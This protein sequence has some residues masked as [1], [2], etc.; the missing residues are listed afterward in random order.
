MRELHSCVLYPIDTAMN[1]VS[2]RPQTLKKMLSIILP[3]EVTVLIFLGRSS[4]TYFEYMLSCFVSGS[5]WWFSPLITS[6]D[7]FRESGKSSSW[8]VSSEPTVYTLSG[9]LTCYTQLSSLF[10]Y[11]TLPSLPVFLLWHADHFSP[12][13][14]VWVQPWL[15]YMPG[16]V[17]DHHSYTPGFHENRHS[18]FSLTCGRR[19]LSLYTATT[20]QWILVDLTL[21]AVRNLITPRILIIEFCNVNSIRTVYHYQLDKTHECLDHMQAGMCTTTSDITFMSPDVPLR[22]SKVACSNFN[23]FGCY[24]VSYL[25]V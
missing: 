3:A 10:K 6:N 23:W 21:I 5:K 4:N 24:D 20:Q 12:D 22:Y 9:N 13:L 11:W 25:F 8:W 7:L 16:L 17:S 1:L 18:T 19:S 15:L 2:I 14:W